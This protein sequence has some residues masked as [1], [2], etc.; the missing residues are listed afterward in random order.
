MRLSLIMSPRKSV[1][2]FQKIMV[3]IYIYIYNIYTECLFRIGA[4]VFEKDQS[5][6]TE[7]LSCETEVLYCESEVLS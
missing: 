3:P 2:L 5:C 6:E 7:V 1:R 4:L